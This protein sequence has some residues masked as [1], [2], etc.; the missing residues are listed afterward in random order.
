MKAVILSL[1]T[2]LVL[3]FV[4]S[5]QT[6]EAA[7]L[8]LLQERVK[9]LTEQIQATLKQAAQSAVTPTPTPTAVSSQAATPAEDEVVKNLR[10]TVRA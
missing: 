2:I 5:A 3:P 4:V 8:K 10:D 6:D 7:T 9:T 1:I